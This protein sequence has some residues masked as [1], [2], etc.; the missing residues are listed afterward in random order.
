MQCIQVLKCETIPD[1]SD[2]KTITIDFD[3]FDEDDDDD[4]DDD[5]FK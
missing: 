2:Y 1:N 3:D 5:R 4:D